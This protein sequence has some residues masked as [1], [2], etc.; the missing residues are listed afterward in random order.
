[1]SILRVPAALVPS[2]QHY[3][4]RVSGQ[5]TVGELARYLAQ[6]DAQVEANT[7]EIARPARPEQRIDDL[8]I[9]GGDRLLIFT[10]EARPAELPTP[11]RPGDKIIEFRLGDTVIPSRGKK[12]LMVGKPE[13]GF[14]PDVDLRRFIAPNLLEPV[15]ADCLRFYFDPAAQVW[16]AARSGETLIMLDEIALETTPVALNDAQWVRFYR[17]GDTRPIGEMHITLETVQVGEDLAL[18]P[19]GNEAASLRIGME[20]ESQ[21]LKVSGSIRAAQIIS[22]L[23]QY[24]RLPISVDASL[25]I[26]RLVAPHTTLDM[27]RLGQGGLL[28]A[29]LKLRYSQTVLVLR[30]VQRPERTYTLLAGQEERLIGCRPQAETPLPE[31]DIDLYDAIIGQGYDPRPFQGMSPY[32]ARIVYRADEQSW[33]IRLDERSQVPLFVNNTR[34]SRGTSLPLISGDIVSIGPSLSLPYARLEVG[35]E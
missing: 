31:L 5:V 1:M 6:V 33:W 21:T 10:H 19:A 9:Q 12:S 13:A 18:L 30:D 17:P 27:A 4:T 32:Y 22:S 28:Y 15:S 2:S 23:A 3:Q 26:A 8:D 20:K 24:N 7:L 16:Y 35:E 29:A 11:M 34:A 14:I 25:Y